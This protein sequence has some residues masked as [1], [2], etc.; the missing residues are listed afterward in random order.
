LA[1]G[2]LGARVALAAATAV[3][4]KHAIQEFKA[5]PLAAQSYAHKERSKNHLASH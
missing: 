1:R 4:P 5:E 2:D 3:Q